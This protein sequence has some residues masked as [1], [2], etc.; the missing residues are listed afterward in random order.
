MSVFSTLGIAANGV[1]AVAAGWVEID[2]RL[3]WRWIQ[4]IHLMYEHARKSQLELTPFLQ[5]HWCLL[6]PRTNRD[7]RN[8]LC[9][10]A[11]Q[12]SRKTPQG[13]S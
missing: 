5:N 9:D 6:Y 2:K 4:W 7:E 11:P 8:A 12:D 13:K 10:I 1:G 3:G